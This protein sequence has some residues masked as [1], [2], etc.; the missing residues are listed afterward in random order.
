MRQLSGRLSKV[1]KG[2]RRETENLILLK[3]I[4]IKDTKAQDIILKICKREMCL[5]RVFDI[6]THFS[7]FRQGERSRG[8]LRKLQAYPVQRW[9]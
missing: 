3:G 7:I 1:S 6:K 5:Q 4:E 2:Q 9:R 8:S